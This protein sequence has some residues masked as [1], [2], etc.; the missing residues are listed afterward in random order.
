MK[1]LKHLFMSPDRIFMIS[2]QLVNDTIDSILHNP[3]LIQYTDCQVCYEYILIQIFS[4][5]KNSKAA[6]D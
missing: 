4:W 6:V 5:V 1:D 2:P 3:T